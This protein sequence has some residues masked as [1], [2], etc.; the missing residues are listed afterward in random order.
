L[1]Q[2]D[3]ARMCYE[4]ILE[5]YQNRE[6]YNNLGILSALAAADLTPKNLDKL[7]FPYEIDWNTRLSRKKRGTETMTD[8]VQTQRLALL[9]K[10]Q[11]Y[12][13]TATRMDKSYTVA[14]VNHLC[15]L[16]QMGKIDEALED[17]AKLKKR[18]NDP[19][20]QAHAKL[21]YA[22]ILSKKLEKLEESKAILEQLSRNASKS[23][24]YNKDILDN[25][26]VKF[27]TSSCDF[28]IENT[29][30]DNAQLHKLSP[31]GHTLN[32]NSTAR[33]IFQKLENSMVVQA[34]IQGKYYFAFQR[35]K[36]FLPQNAENTEGGKNG[37]V[38]M[39]TN[40]SISLCED[41]QV[42]FRYDNA[43]KVV[44]WLRFYGN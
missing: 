29:Q 13:E 9:K 19:F 25:K 32:V 28:K 24:A 17:Y 44:E 18:L 1:G 43:H 14:A 33:L 16:A 26:T 41:Q 23:V 42:A 3:F 22:L 39:T 34:K 21:A 5:V 36:G 15:V 7:V 10:A 35:I 2:Y 31:K 37:N 38:V 40:G 12:F 20:E 11:T 30:I 27:G 4:H 8:E 6:I